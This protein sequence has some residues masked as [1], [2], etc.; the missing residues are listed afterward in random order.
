[1]AVVYIYKGIRKNKG[2][3]LKLNEGVYTNSYFN[4][5]KFKSIYQNSN[6]NVGDILIKSIEM[7][8]NSVITLY[9][10]DNN[11]NII[12]TYTGYT[13]ELKDKNIISITITKKIEKFSLNEHFLGK[14]GKSMLLYVSGPFV[15]MFLLIIVIY[16]Y[17]FLQETKPT[18]PTKP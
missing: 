1:M 10:D 3:A 14:E 15:L 5:T 4:N 12:N 9:S 8:T 2:T 7:A 13:Y 18:K 6:Y 17:I 11:I 16:I